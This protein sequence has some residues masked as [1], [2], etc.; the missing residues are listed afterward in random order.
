MV[1][2]LKEIQ[3]ILQVILNSEHDVPLEVCKNG[4]IKRIVKPPN[5][6]QQKNTIGIPSTRTK[7]YFIE[8]HGGFA[9]IQLSSYSSHVKE[10]AYDSTEKLKE[11]NQA[12]IDNLKSGRY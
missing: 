8:L 5:D 12:Y 1:N 3:K 6:D 2:E 10:K 11:L 9:V 4:I 7:Q